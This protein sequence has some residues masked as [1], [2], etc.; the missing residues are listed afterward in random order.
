MTERAP[1]A[2][3]VAGVLADALVIA[4]RR[5]DVV[6]AL[7]GLTAAPELPTEKPDGALLT[8]REL[9]EALSV[10]CSTV[11][12]LTRE[13]LPIAAH[14]GDGRRYDLATCR[15]WRG[16]RGRRPTK[17]SRRSSEPEVAIEDVA[18]SAGLRRTR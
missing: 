7:R 1:L 6:E 5:P 11:D 2:E 3:A 8:K 18:E 16:A 13:G 17:A 15:A 9:A 12:R 10:S 14:V 4:L